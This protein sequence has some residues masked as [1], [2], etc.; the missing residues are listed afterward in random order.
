MSR[1][2]GWPALVQ[3]MKD[4]T[5]QVRQTLK[6]LLF[7]SATVRQYCP[8]GLRDPQSEVSVW[9]HGLGA[10]HDV[11]ESNVVAATQPLTL[12]IGFGNDLNLAAVRRAGLSLKFRER[13]RENRLLGEMS[14]RLI[15]AIS[16][17]GGQMLLFE[18][19]HCRNYCVA[20]PWLWS[21]YLYFSY[22]QWRS[23][24]RSQAS[25]LQVPASDLHCLFVF[26]LCPRPVVLVSVAHA[27][28]VNIVPMDL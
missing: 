11:T 22:R 14:L 15:E 18:P 23:G 8:I 9:L 27:D 5:N 28:R 7:G 6:W 17:A 1:T 13:Q 24:K 10:P 20:R 21:R 3:N 19:H 26:Y 25:G 16:L 4:T 12:G 2:L